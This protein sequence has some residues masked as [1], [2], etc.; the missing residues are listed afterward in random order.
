MNNVEIIQKDLGTVDIIG[1]CP[2]CEHTSHFIN[3]DVFRTMSSVNCKNCNKMMNI[4]VSEYID[5]C[6]FENNIKSLIKDRKIA[7]WPITNGVVEMFNKSE[8]LKSENVFLVNSA[9]FKQSSNFM[10]KIVQR[11][12]IINEYKIDTVIITST[13]TVTSEIV[14]IINKNYKTVKNIIY[15]GKL[16][17]KNFTLKN[18]E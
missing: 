3:L 1:D 2:N 16:I 14:N 9:R 11:P 5:G 13:T 4:F 12:E 10:G 18:I 7:L 15:A 17:D 6:T 8:S